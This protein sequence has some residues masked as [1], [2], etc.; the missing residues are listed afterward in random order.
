MHMGRPQ[1]ELWQGLARY[2]RS[3]TGSGK[4]LDSYDLKTIEDWK[5]RDIP[6][7]TMAVPGAADRMAMCRRNSN[8]SG[9]QKVADIWREQKT[10]KVRFYKIC[11]DLSD[12]ACDGTPIGYLAIKTQKGDIVTY[13]FAVEKV[14]AINDS[15]G[16]IAFVD[17]SGG[18]DKGDIEYELYGGAYLLYRPGETEPFVSSDKF[19]TDPIAD[20]LMG[21]TTQGAGNVNAEINAAIMAIRKADELGYRHIRVYYDCEQ[22]GGHAPGGAYKKHESKI[23]RKYVQFLSDYDFKALNKI[24]LVHVDGHVGVKP[25][26]DV[27]LKAKC[28]RDTVAVEYR[29]DEAKRAL[30]LEHSKD[31]SA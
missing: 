3:L 17:G 11:D 20:G 25:N 2:S 4:I 14:P 28:A 1:F 5:I 31:Y 7:F 13:D 9:L 8:I 23:S 19:E 10:T 24:E 16:V 15:E 6:Q 18:G 26:E 12:I 27:D 21:I 30:Y 22:I 29:T